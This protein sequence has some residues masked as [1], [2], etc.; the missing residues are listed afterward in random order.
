MRKPAGLILRGGYWHIQK[1]V[2]VGA[3]K[4]RIREAT[5]C[6]EKDIGSAREYLERRTF[7]VQ[8]ELRGSENGSSRTFAEAAVEYV[9]SLGLRGKSTS[10]AELNLRRVMDTIGNTLLGH[11]HQGTL[12]PWIDAQ[13]GKLK[14]ATVK[15]T[16]AVVTAVLNHA[17]R[18]LRDGNTPWLTT[19]V[20]KLQAPDWN[21]AKQPYRLTWEEQD[22]LISFLPAHLVGPALFSL[23]TGA[24]EQE[25]A[26]LKWDQECRVT[27]LPVGSI[28]WIPPGVRKG[29]ARKTRSEQEGRYLVCNATARSV[30]NVQREN[31]SDY[32]FP[33][34]SGTRVAR[35]N[36][37]GFRTARTKAELPLR[38]HDLRH[39]FGERAA[40]AGVPW[41][42]RKV[43]LGHEI[44][45]ITAHYSAPGLKMLLDEA[46]KITR[47]GAFVLRAVTQNV[48]QK[49]RRA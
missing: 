14:S 43:L 10:E 21:D 5:G 16:L 28:W 34:T 3:R 15:R 42:Y 13:H 1:V 25:V 40:A 35:L 30:L 37:H 19:A 20:P 44:G 22:R 4:R 45:D 46:E 38:W 36:N 11:V 47:E 41:D 7:E 9:S 24:R 17:A 27:G 48:T 39:T 2:R 8:V 32:V 29:N 23:A 6:K 31:G 26:A 33:G 49:R 12:L 18:V